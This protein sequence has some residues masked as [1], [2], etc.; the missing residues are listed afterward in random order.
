MNEIII[1]N[2]KQKF[3]KAI[4]FRVAEET[5]NN[6]MKVL[7]ETKKS[8]SETMR[9]LTYDFLKAKKEHEKLNGG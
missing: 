2:N 7:D 4:N 3:D 1:E 8:I 6:L 5:Y 9:R